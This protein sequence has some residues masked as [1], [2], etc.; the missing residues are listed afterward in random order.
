MTET[1]YHIAE[2]ALYSCLEIVQRTT[3]RSRGLGALIPPSS[4][5]RDET[6]ISIPY[7]STLLPAPNVAMRDKAAAYKLAKNLLTCFTKHD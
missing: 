2:S 1:T 3:T 4:T 6:L 5:S 7:R